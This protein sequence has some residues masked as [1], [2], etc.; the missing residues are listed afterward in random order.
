LAF[1]TILG[2]SYYGERC[3]EF[4]FGTKYLK[5]YRIIFA[6]MVPLGG[7]LTLDLIWL[8]ADIVN[9]LMALP[10]LL[11]VLALSR[12]VIS[13]TKEYFVRQ[14]KAADAEELVALADN[15]VED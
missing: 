9:G 10:I 5:L 4:L 8:L 3:F 15:L 12:I 13:D 14:K 7:F 2:W 1:T 6:I 11:A